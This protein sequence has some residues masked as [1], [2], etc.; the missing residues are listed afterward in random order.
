M[1]A[2][3][4]RVAH[5]RHPLKGALLG[6]ICSVALATA[7]SPASA[8]TYLVAN[9]AQ[10]R[11]AILDANADGDANS[12]ITLTGS[13]ALTNVTLP[14]PTKPIAIEEPASCNVNGKPERRV[15]MI[16]TK[17][18]KSIMRGPCLATPEPSR[19][20]RPIRSR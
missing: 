8:A 9:D 3:L 16:S 17:K 10:L 2:S 7:W 12:T 6:G 13:F 14:S 1:S 4:R 19:S 5:V 20:G 11:Q 15:G 18:A